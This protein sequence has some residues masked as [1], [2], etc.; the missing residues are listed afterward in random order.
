MSSLSRPDFRRRRLLRYGAL[1]LLGG[2][3]S[4]MIQSALANGTHPVPPGLHRVQGQVLVNGQPARPGMLIQPRDRIETGPGSE[5]IYV[6]GQDAYLQRASSS[7]EIGAGSQAGEVA[8]SGLRLIAGKLLSVFGRGRQRLE[9][10]TATIGI[11]GTGCYMEAEPERLYICLC[12]GEADYIPRVAPRLARSLRTTHHEEPVWISA[13]DRENPISP[14]PMLNHTDAE[15]VLL[16]NLVGRWPPFYG[17]GG[18][19]Y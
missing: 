7:V 13:R 19:S 9:T 15:L 2:G 16:E 11:R 8:A 14:A 12:Y 17:Q 10:P 4:G 18:P 1:P 5:A 3:L 6:V